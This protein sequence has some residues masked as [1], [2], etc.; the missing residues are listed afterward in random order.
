MARKVVDALENPD[1]KPIRPASD[2][3]DVL[4]THEP[5]VCLQNPP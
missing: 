2:P 1:P 3:V 5:D 4:E